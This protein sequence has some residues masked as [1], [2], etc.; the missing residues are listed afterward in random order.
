MFGA[1]YYIAKNKIKSKVHKHTPITLE[2]YMKLK[3]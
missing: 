2:E 3:K 1:L